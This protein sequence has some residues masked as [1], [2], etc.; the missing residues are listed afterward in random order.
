MCKI[1]VKRRNVRLNK[2]FPE[3]REPDRQ[4]LRE[5]RVNNGS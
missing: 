2:L 4:V 5:N 1:K 3:M